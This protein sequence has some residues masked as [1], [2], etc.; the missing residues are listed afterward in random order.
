MG[1]FEIRQG[2]FEIGQGWNG[3]VWDHAGK[4]NLILGEIKIG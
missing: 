2:K 4:E 1:E 3:W